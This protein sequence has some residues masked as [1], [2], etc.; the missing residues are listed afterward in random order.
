VET[1]FMLLDIFGIDY[2]VFLHLFVIAGCD[3]F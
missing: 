1:G 2:P 3:K